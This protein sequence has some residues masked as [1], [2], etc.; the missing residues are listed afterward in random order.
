MK[1]FYLPAGV[2]A[3]ILAC[4]LWAGRFL[5]MRTEHWTALLAGVSQAAEAEDW[6]GASRA[7]R[8]AYEDWDRDQTFLHTI[9]EHDALD[10]AATSVPS[11]GVLPVMAR[12]LPLRASTAAVP[13]SLAS[14][15]APAPVLMLMIKVLPFSS[16]T[17]ERAS[18]P[19]ERERG[20]RPLTTVRG[21]SCRWLLTTL[22]A[23][24]I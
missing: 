15:S 17:L 5:E 11:P 24:L 9:L 23:P 19:A 2:L 6:S 7:L 10:E 4:S 3:L 14:T 12:A 22:S 13:L 18:P 21:M 20:R 8:Q 16:S 1:V